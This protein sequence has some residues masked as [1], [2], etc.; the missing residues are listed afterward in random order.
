MHFESDA[1]FSLALVVSLEY[2]Y[3]SILSVQASIYTFHSLY[4]ATINALCTVSNFLLSERRMN[5]ERLEENNQ[6]SAQL[7]K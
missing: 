4:T 6:V 5:E 3:S 2:V 7:G 1:D